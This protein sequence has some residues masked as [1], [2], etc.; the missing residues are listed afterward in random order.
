M[1][2]SLSS[3]DE[4]DL[5]SNTII[6]VPALDLATVLVWVAPTGMFVND[7]YMSG[8]V[9]FK[10]LFY[11]NG[12]RKLSLWSSTDSRNISRVLQAPLIVKQGDILELKVRHYFDANAEFD[13]S[14]A[15]SK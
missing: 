5:V 10:M 1:S 8:N 12:E 11:L 15:I 9:S 2:R 7:I 6:A 13:A 4:S 14:F 3:L